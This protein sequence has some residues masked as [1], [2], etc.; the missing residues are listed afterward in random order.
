MPLS[1]MVRL[2]GESV[3]PGP[4]PLRFEAAANSFARSATLPSSLLLG[5]ISS[6]S[7]QAT[8]RLPLMPSSM[9]QKKSAWSRRTLRLST[10]RVRPPVPGN[11]AVVG[12]EDVIGC[13]RQFITAAGRGP[14]DDGDEALPGIPGGIFQAVAGLVG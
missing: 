14:V 1:S 2:S 9:V 5:T 4:E 7:R 10:T 13:E 6:T 3:M 12:E 11:T 8:A